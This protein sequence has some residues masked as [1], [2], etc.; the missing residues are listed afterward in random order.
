MFTFVSKLKLTKI[1]LFLPYSLRN[2]IKNFI[3]Y[4]PYPDFSK[5]KTSLEKVDVN[6]KK[7]FHF[8]T[9]IGSHR[10]SNLLDSSLAKYLVDRGHSV[11]VLICDENLPACLNSSIWKRKKKDR[12]DNTLSESPKKQDLCKVCFKNSEELWKST[13][14]KIYKISDLLTKAD[15]KEINE[16]VKNLKLLGD[17]FYKEINLRED[18]IAGCLRY[19]CLGDENK[20]SEELYERYA[21]SSLRICFCYEKILSIESIDTGVWVHGIYVPHGILNK[22]FNKK[23]INFY[24]YN[25]SYRENRFYFTKNDTYHKVFPSESSEQLS[26]DSFTES[27]LKQAKE[28][29]V[30][31]EKGSQDWQQFNNEPLKDSLKELKKIGF[32]EDK[33]DLAVLF[34]NVVWDARLHFQ[35][36]LYDDMVDWI[37][38][39]VN[40][41]KT[42]ATKKLIIRV[43]PGELISHSVS[44]EKVADLDF[45]QSLPENIILVP[46]ESKISSYFLASISKLNLVYATKMSME[47]CL[48]DAPI[49]CCGDAWVKGKNAT[50]DPNSKKEFLEILN[51]ENWATLNNKMNKKNGLSYSHYIFEKKP[52]YFPYFKVAKDRKSFSVDLSSYE[53]VY[54]GEES[55]L[56]FMES[57]LTN[58]EEIINS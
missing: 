21:I 40:F 34:T 33:K 14:A 43:H 23:Q 10:A 55:V 9:I 38:D 36:N 56:N 17:V 8:G 53:K 50:I 31:R 37:K 42:S 29:L 57:K 44:R 25:T 6:T 48:Y 58:K 54:L 32:K 28:Y 20:I 26:L 35:E 24:N 39:I 11:S 13:N 5:L 46:P 30:S 49:I 22:I 12:L 47:L 4:S 45:L 19:L 41:F 27:E 2:L 18:I 16:K 51:L 7:N 52:I 15:H 1:W 3:G